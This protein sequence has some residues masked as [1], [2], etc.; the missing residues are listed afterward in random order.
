MKGTPPTTLVCGVGNP[1]RGDDGIGPEIVSRLER[2]RGAGRG[3]PEPAIEVR[4]QL[5]VEDALIF[6]RFERVIIVDASK[7]SSVPFSLER[8][9][10]QLG[11]SFSSHALSAAAVLA[12]C[13]DLYGR[14]PEAYLLAVRG[15][16]WEL[17]D[18]LSP[19]AENNIRL[20]LEAL[21]LLLED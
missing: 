11:L 19:A 7:T 10:P 5:N 4:L 15:V 16:S 18:G 6:S 13:R 9:E 21:S 8:L 20:A 14:T 1:G 3:R 12:W 17:G 2:E